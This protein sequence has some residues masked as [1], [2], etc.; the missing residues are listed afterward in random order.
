MASSGSGTSVHLSGELFKMMTG[1]EHGARALQ[2]A[3]APALTDL[4]GG[5]VQVMFD[6]LPSSIGYIQAGKLRALA[7]TTATRATGVA[8]RADGGRDGAGLRGERLV[9][10]R[11]AARERRADDHRQAEPE[12]NAALADPKHAG[13]PRRTRRHRSPARR[14]IS[15]RSSPRRP[16]NGPRWSRPPAPRRNSSIVFRGRCLPSPAKRDGCA[17]PATRGRRG[18]RARRL[19]VRIMSAH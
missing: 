17:G 9:R 14:R 3:P 5:Q 18:A 10:H 19:M 8:G 16:R 11:R 1:V 2:A 15:A 4:M 12:V 7:V 13:A 6:N